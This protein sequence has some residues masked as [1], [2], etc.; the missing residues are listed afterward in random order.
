MGVLSFVETTYMIEDG[1]S[2]AA[3]VWGDPNKTPVIALHGWL[4]NANTFDKIASL[5]PDNICLVALDMAGHGKSDHRRQ[6]S[7]YYLWDYAI[8]V[9]KVADLLKWKNF[10]VLAHSLGTGVASIIAGAMNERVDKLIFIDGLGAPFVSRNDAG[11]VADFKKSL[12]QLE[13][14]KKT[15]LFG[16]VGSKTPQFETKEEA[17]NDRMNSSIGAI[18]YDASRILVERSISDVEGGVRWRFDPRLVLPKPFSL[19]ESQA[20][21]FISQITCKTQII[22]GKQG[23]FA[24][25]LFSDRIAKFDNIQIHKLE[26]GHH[27]HLEEAYSQVSTLINQ[28]LN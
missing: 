14:A 8:D 11:V 3:K 17:I 26:G 12:R 16:F 25:G 23:M 1:F 6:D 28:F 5:L 24:D 27:L 15:N 18:G 20:Q 10:S 19:T 21:C 13:M 4:D 22:L 2:I 9:L 7:S